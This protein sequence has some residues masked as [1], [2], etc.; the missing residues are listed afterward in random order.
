MGEYYEFWLLAIRL[1]MLVAGLS[2]LVFFA[3]E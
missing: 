2:I 1:G 3:I